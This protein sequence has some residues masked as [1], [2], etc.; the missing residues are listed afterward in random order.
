[1]S[2]LCIGIDLGTTYSSIT[3]LNDHGEPEV[4]E[5][6]EGERTTP[7]VVLFD[8]DDI[9]VGSERQGQLGGLPGADGGVR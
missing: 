2:K 4:L 8:G 1:M 3:W 5:N 9:V 7:S 6:E